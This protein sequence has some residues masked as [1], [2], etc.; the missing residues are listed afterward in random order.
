MSFPFD[1]GTLQKELKVINGNQRV[2]GDTES[3]NM[4]S[5]S[6][7]SVFKTK[8]ACQTVGQVSSGTAVLWDIKHSCHKSESHWGCMSHGNS[9]WP[10]HTQNKSS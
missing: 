2:W 9:Q 6:L 5:T 3:V 4:N 8:K 7:Y 10:C 1:G